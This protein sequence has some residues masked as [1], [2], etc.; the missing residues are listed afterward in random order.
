MDKRLVEMGEI[1][2]PAPF[3]PIHIADPKTITKK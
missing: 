2:N 3:S 1:Q